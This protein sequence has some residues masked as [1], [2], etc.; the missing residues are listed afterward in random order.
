[1][2]GY[3]VSCERISVFERLGS[4]PQFDIIWSSQSV[5][6]HLEFFAQLKGL[7]KNQVKASAHSIAN[8]GG[9]GVSGGLDLIL[10]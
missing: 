5:R 2:S 6:W 1:M 7:P 10:W 8:S 9:N 3:D 4:C